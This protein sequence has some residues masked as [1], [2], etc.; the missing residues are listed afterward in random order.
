VS[1]VASAGERVGA[2]IAATERLNPTLNAYLHLDLEGARAAAAEQD[3][4]DAARGAIADQTAPEAAP[5]RA[6]PGGAAPGAGADAS[7]DPSRPLA[8]MPICVKDIVDVAGMPTTAGGADWMR[9]PDADATIVERLRTAGAVVVGKGNTNEFACGIDGRNPHKGDCRN[10]YDPERLTGGSSSGPAAAVASGMAEGGVGSDTSGSI[11]IP[12]ALCG[13]VGIRPTRGLVPAD[14]VVP[15]AWSLDAVGPLARDVPAAALLLDLMAGRPARPSPR[16]E[17]RGLRLGLATELFDRCEEPVAE[18]LGAAVELLR[19]ADA[20]IVD[21]ALPDLERAT[22]IHR[23]VQACEVA[24]AH[25]PWFA[26]QRD[27]YAPEVR[28]RIEPGYSLGAEVYLRAQRHRRLFTHAFAAT[29]D[30]L[31][32]VLAPASPILAPRIAAEEVRVRG[33]RRDVRDALL[34]C[35]VPF[36]QLDS[37]AVSVP[38]GLREGLPV[39]LQVLGRPRSEDLLLRIAATAEGAAEERPG[40]IPRPSFQSRRLGIGPA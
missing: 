17:V 19:E 13:V 27:R 21:V 20:E 31:D 22:A 14:G 1:A 38:V 35:V 18:A 10:P 23:I 28:A 4:I 11:R 6:M 36:S 3:A 9:R 2:A 29:M 37:P 15:L 12:A 34:S 40:T 32:A 25:A 7:P 26:T 30:G 8:G 24:A 33:E 5:V 39:G 16:P